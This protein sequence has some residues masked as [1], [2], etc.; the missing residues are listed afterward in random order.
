MKKFQNLRFSSKGTHR[1]KIG[2]GTL[3]AEDL[4]S[5]QWHFHFQTPMSLVYVPLQHPDINDFAYADNELIVWKNYAVPGLSILQH[6]I[7]VSVFRFCAKI[8]YELSKR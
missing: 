2:T 7:W 3:H 4:E 6:E 1:R 8:F 5:R